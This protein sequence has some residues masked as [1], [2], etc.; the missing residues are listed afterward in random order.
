MYTKQ[1][2]LRAVPHAP[3]LESHAHEAGQ[4][5]GVT[6]HMQHPDVVPALATLQGDV[7][8]GSAHWHETC[9]KDAL[10]HGCWMSPRPQ[11]DCEEHGIRRLCRLGA[12]V[13]VLPHLQH[14]DGGHVQAGSLRPLELQGEDGGHSAGLPLAAVRLCPVGLVRVLLHA[15]MA[16][17]QYI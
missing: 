8:L 17:S 9:D 6:V 11:T 1:R 5:Q 12:V 2:L 13:W 4:A 15:G 16:L 3:W 14:L 10:L 7:E